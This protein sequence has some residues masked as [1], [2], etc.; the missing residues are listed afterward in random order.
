VKPP[1]YLDRDGV[2]NENRPDYV[3]HPG[4]LVP[5]A[6]AVESVARLTGA[7]HSVIVVTN[8]SG[9]AR[10]Y[11]TSCDVQLIHEVIG[12]AFKA[13]GVDMN[14]I[15][16]YFCPHHPDDHCCCRKP[17]TGMIDAAR[18]ELSLPLGGWIIGDADS[19][20]ELGRRCGLKTILVLS[21]RGVSQLQRIKA[22]KGVLPD[23]VTGSIAAA[24]DLI[25]THCEA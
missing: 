13:A 23:H 3:R 6:G 11:Y 5:I 2:I 14:R 15:A 22:A 10:G 16:F 24:C 25:L 8:Q 7:G 4:H 1:V 20:M 18:G 12:A 9:I 21:G 19:D 17:M